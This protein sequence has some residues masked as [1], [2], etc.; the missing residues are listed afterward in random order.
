M[1][2]IAVCENRNKHIGA[3]KLMLQQT[4][5]CIATEKQILMNGNN[6]PEEKLVS[7]KIL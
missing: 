5:I 2:T 1:A 7:K 4:D 6:L 3:R